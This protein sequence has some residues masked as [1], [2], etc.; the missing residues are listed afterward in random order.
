MDY[1][2]DADF[3]CLQMASS[4]KRRTQLSNA[5]RLGACSR[6][7]AQ[8]CGCCLLVSL[9]PRP[10]SQLYY[11]TAT[12]VD[13]SAAAMWVWVRDYLLAHSGTNLSEDAVR[14]WRHK[15]LEYWEQQ[16]ICHESSK[17]NRH[18]KYPSLEATLFI[19]M[20]QVCGSIL[21]L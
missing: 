15:G 14:K 3:C 5:E 11:I 8:P 2:S 4:K 6:E 1:L 13:P 19:W 21:N 18:D 20:K 16:G 9:V 12:R 17:R 7:S 10:T